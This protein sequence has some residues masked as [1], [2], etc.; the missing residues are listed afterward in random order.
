MSFLNSFVE[1][2]KIVPSPWNFLVLSLTVIGLLTYLT[3][4]FIVFVPHGHKAM[5]M[6]GRR[7]IF[8]KK[9]GQPIICNAGMRL[10]VPWAYSLEV[11]STLD[12][13]FD[14]R[15]FTIQHGEYWLA[16][17]TSTAVF[18]VDSI[19][20]VRYGADDFANRLTSACEAAL[21]I[22]LVNIRPDQIDASKRE[23]DATFAEGIRTVAFELGTTFRELNITNVATNSQALVASAIA[24]LNGGQ[25]VALE[26]IGAAYQ[27]D[28]K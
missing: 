12:R 5:R 23:I 9:T 20:R 8:S 25:K 17:I 14:L 11:V 4:R 16:E 24:S 27:D 13:T 6:R 26:A 28:Q 2:Y 7:V 3:S 18:T 15:T 10:V 1:I 21:R 22:C 19:Y